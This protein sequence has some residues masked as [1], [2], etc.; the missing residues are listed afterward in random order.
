MTLKAVLFDFNGIIINDEPIHEELIRDILLQENLRPDTKDYQQ[1]CLGRSDRICLQ[2]ILRLRG[3]ELKE[4]EIDKLIAN[5]SASYEKKL[6]ELEKI[7]IYKGLQEFLERLQ[8]AQLKIG[9]V[10]GALRREV[11]IVLNLSSLKSYFSVIVTSDEVK[12]SK[13]APDGYLLAMDKLNQKFPYL[14]LQQKNCLVIEDTLAGIE[15]GKNAGMQVVGVANTYPFHMLQ[16]QANW[17]V[18]YFR[19]VE[20]ERIQ[21]V[22]ANLPEMAVTE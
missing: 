13:P 11:D 17:T 18:D 3:R 10:T 22:F 6:T 14:Q 2:E 1:V 5:K 7:P 8:Q 16:R 15:A 20:L 19:E 21:K 12:N 4:A 9:L